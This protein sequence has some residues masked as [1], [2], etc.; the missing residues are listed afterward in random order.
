M[1]M[2]YIG[3]FLG[4]LTLSLMLNVPRRALITGSIFG[5]IAYWIYEQ[6]AAHGAMQTGIFWGA[7]AGALLS[8]IAARRLRAT[9]SAFIIPAIIPLVPGVGLYRSMLMVAQGDLSG[10]S[11]LGVETAIVFCNISLAVACASMLVRTWQQFFHKRE[12]PLPPSDAN[13]PEAP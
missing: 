13:T 9:A 6:C 12:T 2:P 5:L 10:A 4:T 1:L 3:C 7:L 8:E 11:S